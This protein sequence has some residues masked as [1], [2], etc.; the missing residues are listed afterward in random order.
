MTQHLAVLPCWQQAVH[1]PQST[2]D[3]L[4]YAA[5]VLWLLPC[6][7]IVIN[8]LCASSML[9]SYVHAMP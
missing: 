4:V 9:W 8:G 2:G 5:G 6:R 7:P 3:D 1:V